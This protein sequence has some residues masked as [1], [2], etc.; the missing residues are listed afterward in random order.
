MQSASIKYIGIPFGINYSKIPYLASGGV[1]L[2]TKYVSEDRNGARSFISGVLLLS[3][4]TVIVK[5][6]GLAFKI[7]MLSFLGAEGMG[8]FNSAYEIY[9]LLCIISTAGLPVALSMLV[10]SAR[11]E[12][13]A[14]RVR[15]VYRS[16]KYIFCAIGLCASLLMIIFARSLAE[17]IGNADAYLCI[18]AIA[19]ALLSVCL[20]SAVRGYCQ[21][22]EYMTPTAISQLIEAV[23]KLAF[24]ILFSLVAIKKGYPSFAVAAFAVSGISVG[25]FVSLVYLVAVKRIKRPEKS[26]EGCCRS[27][28]VYHHKNSARELIAIAL[29]ITLGSAVIGLTRIIDTALIMRRLGE[30]GLSVARSNEIYG[31]YTTLAIPVF[32]LIPAL[33]TPISMALVPQLSAFR[34]NGDT[35]GER[36]VIEN[37]FRLTVLLAMPASFG[38]T[39]F[40][41]PVL[42]VLFSG[43]TEAISIAAPLLAALGPSVLFSCLI[44]TTNAILQ[45]YR[46]VCLPIVSMGV[47]VVAK[48]VGT[49]FLLRVDG[50]SVLGAPIGSLLCNVTVV[51]INLCFMRAHTSERLKAS[52]ILF[53]PLLVSVVSVGGAYLLYA[54]MQSYFGAILLPFVF[55]V[56]LAA[57]MYIGLSFLIGSLSKKDIM[58]LPYG[59]KII[60]FIDSRKNKKI[61]ISAKINNEEDKRR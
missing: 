15:S 2:K 23:G 16:A 32:G 59:E 39:L 24:G 48:L 30:M 51:V 34:Q 13:D 43:Q 18:I 44:T 29:P 19:P 46:H 26:L 55:A 28:N 38:L 57:L 7:P 54:Y 53:K 25:A 49:Y 20:S 6:I 61:K 33:I 22:F 42:E 14:L 58:L 50:I 47:G 31:S 10:S 27:I 52:E 3:F 45:S 40:S 1:S 60:C 4:S 17:F 37:S 35:E 8:Y 21:G 5:I 12:N 9:A 41:K 36:S 11:A 56:M